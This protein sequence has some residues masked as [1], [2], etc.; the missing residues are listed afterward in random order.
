MDY[1]FPAPVDQGPFNMSQVEVDL[2]FRY[3]KDLGD[4]QGTC[5][6]LFQ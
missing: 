1:Q 3:T 6:F 4:I 2:F 5:L